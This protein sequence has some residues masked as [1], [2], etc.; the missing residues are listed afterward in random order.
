MVAQRVYVGVV[1]VE[2]DT[3]LL[4]DYRHTQPLHLMAS[5]IVAKQLWV[6]Q[7]VLAQRLHHFV[8][9]HL[10]AR[11]QDVDLVL[12]FSLI[13]IDAEADGKQQEHAADA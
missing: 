2:D 9:I 7:T 5:H 6:G 10:E 8:V 12:L 11:V 13:L 4:V 3:S 1:A